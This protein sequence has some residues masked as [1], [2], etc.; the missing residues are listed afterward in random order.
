VVRLS[1]TD[2]KDGG[3]TVEDSV[4]LAGLLREHG[5]DIVDVSSGGNAADAQ[6]TVGPGYQVDFARRIRAEAEMPTGAVGMIT[7]PKQAE[8]VIASGAADVVLL[9]RALLRDPHWALRAAHELGVR[10]GEGVDWPPQYLRA[11][12][13]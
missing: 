13:D 1:A 12:L 11:L 10:A 6:I 7:E 3:W 8:E 9:A 5:V 2:W 4:R